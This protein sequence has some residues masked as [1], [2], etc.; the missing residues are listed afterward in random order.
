[1]T[2]QSDVQPNSWSVTVLWS[3][4][5]QSDMATHTLSHH[6][7]QQLLLPGQSLSASQSVSQARATQPLSNSQNQVQC[8]SYPVKHSCS[9]QE[10]PGRR[11]EDSFQH[12]RQAGLSVG[13]S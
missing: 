10:A 11:T 13:H 3:D 9:H 12:L 7:D 1:M 6:H 2:G 5:L 8:H 4:V